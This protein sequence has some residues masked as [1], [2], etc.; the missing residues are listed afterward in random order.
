MSN[1]HFVSRLSMR[2]LDL[3]LK[4]IFPHFP[5]SYLNDLF[6]FNRK[7]SFYEQFETQISL[8]QFFSMFRAWLL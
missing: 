6:H 2:Q 7:L 4:R 5:S 1:W 3:K 8:N